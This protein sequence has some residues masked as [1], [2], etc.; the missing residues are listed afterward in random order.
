MGAGR[1][2]L[3]VGS[4]KRLAQAVEFYV[5]RGYEYVE[6]PWDVHPAIMAMTCP[7]PE[8]A[9]T[10]EPGFRDLIGSAEQSLLGMEIDVLGTGRYVALTP[11]FRLAD[12]DLGPY[13][14]GYFMK[15]ELYATGPHLRTVVH[16]MA[17]DA[18][19]LFKHLGA[20]DRIKI[21]HPKI[22]G[23]SDSMDIEW[24]GVELGSYGIRTVYHPGLKEDHTWA[25]GTG[26]AEPRFTQVM[27]NIG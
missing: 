4:W 17:M 22:A 23:E 21:T 11:C 19:A 2:N 12:Q 13:H 20:E 10:L 27:R 3:D 5:D 8:R 9:S 16:R 15:V 24:R 18:K 7:S 26:L 6:A 25:Y 1:W 14:H